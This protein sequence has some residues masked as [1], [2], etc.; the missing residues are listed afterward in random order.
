[1]ASIAVNLP[2]DLHEFVLAAVKR[3]H[4]AGADE[5]IVALIRA[6]RD[7]RSEI[8]TALLEGLQGDPAGEWTSQE[9][10]EITLRV[11]QRSE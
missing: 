5:F 7:K 10:A 3:C 4:F 9:S 11:I 2:G 8:E 6:A 1:M